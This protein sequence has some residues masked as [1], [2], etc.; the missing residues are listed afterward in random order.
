MF[1]IL[2]PIL[3]RFLR[4]ESL[5]RLI[6]DLVKAYAKRSDNTVD[7][8]VAAFLEKNLFPPRASK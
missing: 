8:A 4:S 2:K 1:L 7:D 3:L 5:K 6:V